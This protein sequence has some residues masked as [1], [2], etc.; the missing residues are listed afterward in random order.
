[1]FLS[2]STVRKLIAEKEAVQTKDAALI[3]VARSG[4]A[5]DRS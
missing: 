3:E 4:Q 1:M 5:V 2:V